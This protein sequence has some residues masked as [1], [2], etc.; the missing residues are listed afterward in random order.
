ML[1]FRT[2]RW[3]IVTT[4]AVTPC[5]LLHAQAGLAAS[6][7]TAPVAV[8]NRAPLKV[9]NLD[10]YERW[11]RIGAAAM[12][13]DGRWMT[14]TY[15]PNENGD[16]VLHVKALDGD[17]D[18][19]VS[20]GAAAGGAGRGAAP[21]R[22]G[23]IGPSTAPAF[24]DD[25]KWA[26]YLVN[27][28]GRA[29][30][31]AG[32]GRPAPAPS[33]APGGR[34]GTAGAAAAA[35]P[36]RLEILNLASGAKQ[37]IPNVASWKFSAD[38][39][40]LAVRFNRPAAAAGGAAPATAGAAAVPA[41]GGADLILRD[42][43]T[44]T[45]RA[46]GD[47]SQFAF[48]DAGKL[49]A[50]IVDAPEKLGSGVYL[51]DPATGNTRALNTSASQYDALTWSSEGTNLAAL[52]GDKPTTMKQRENVLIA[53]TGLGTSAEQAVVY[54]ARAE[55]AFPKEM[56]L[57]EFA[58]PR[59]N[60]D[61]TRLFV[62]I[63]EQESEIAATDSSKANVD[64]FHWKD[65]IP[66]PVQVVQLAQARR[67]TYPGVITLS[68]GAFARLGDPLMRAVTN[69]ANNRVGVGRSDTLYRGEIAWGAS[70]ADFF[71]VD[72]VTGARTP[73]ANGLSRTYGTSPDSKWFLFLR[74]RQVRAYNME[75]GTT[76]TLDASGIP[77]KSY[78]N[79][80]DDHAYEKPI[81]GLGGWSRDGKSVLLYDKFDIWQAP[82]DGS[83]PTNLTKGLGRAQAI[84][85]RV[86]Q[87]GGGRGGR[88]GAAAVADSDGVDL[89]QPVTLSAYGDRTKK[90]G[91]WKLTA[92]QAPTP[93]VW[94]DK[95]IGG[96]TK[97][98]N[99]DRI[100]YTQQA[101]NEFPD[102]WVA[103]TSFESP[104][105]ITD[106]N[107]LL[108]EYA[109]SPK[110]VLIDYTTSK[111]HKLQGTLML[112]AG[113]EPGKRYPMIVSFY[114]IVS[115]THHNFSIPGYSNS[116]Q[117]STYASNGYL[118]FQ[119]DMVY[120]IGK[121][122][123]S[124][125]DCMTSAVT[126]V[127]E[128]GYADPK[129]IGLHGHS[130]SGYQS[131]Y[132]VTQ[133]NL[134]AAVVTGAPPTNLISFYNELYKSAGTPQQGIT[135]VG[136][137]RMGRNVTPFNSTKLYQDQSPI[138]HVDKIRTPFM[139]LHGVEDGAVDYVEGL[140]FFNA[141]RAAGKQAILLS[142]PGEAHNLT[143]RDNQK[144][145]T[146]RMKQFFDHYLMGMPAPQWMADGLPQTNKGGAI[147]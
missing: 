144:D 38:S 53:W 124:A 60:A 25:S 127:I 13:R 2:S 120:E 72:L 66:Q 117:L 141:A 42:L 50:Y 108:A 131:S 132:I 24:S 90:T 101:F 55:A 54:D 121:P 32:R 19:T 76:V 46:I 130:W 10:D 91:F 95:N 147:K 36:A 5:A 119:P 52:R 84:Q 31:A 143:N 104:R 103:G 139:I 18:Y 34:G 107:P 123:T 129:R 78:V 118:V 79:E 75:N 105:K 33:P 125:V 15:T 51:L 20:L 68:S 23:A 74:N 71:K 92:G 58:T 39:R 65:V 35:T 26:V 14:F 146:V 112:P 87:L 63:K 109:W 45:D 7:N 94:V 69:A 88:G 77:G 80:D 61:G 40:W 62:G 96:V 133:S 29:G 116:P 98:A 6:G 47:V 4:L 48:D 8:G 81:W 73:I 59:W 9:L 12:S 16:P 3:L 37:S 100:M 70:R 56:V 44:G 138:F 82:L 27:P 145:F 113:Y 97:A 85:F 106:A 114:E 102:Y 17:A 140:Q 122:G 57:S 99:A 136:Q 30:G 28:P 43:S 11:N 134:F 128:L 110:K 41:S 67:A 21:A 142:Y 115:N 135:T 83:R 64:V 49:F 89:T 1:A 111:G 22:G 93:V 86:A 137:V 126:K